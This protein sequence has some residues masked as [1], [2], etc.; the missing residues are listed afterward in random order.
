MYALLLFWFLDTV[1]VVAVED[2]QTYQTRYR[3]VT[4][5]VPV[6]LTAC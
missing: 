1:T 4:S 5:V 6:A 3:W 2:A